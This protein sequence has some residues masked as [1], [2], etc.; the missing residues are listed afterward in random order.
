MKLGHSLVA[1]VIA[2]VSEEEA[3][4]GFSVEECLI[5]GRRELKVSI[6]LAGVAE[7]QLKD[8][9]FRVVSDGGKHLR[10]EWLPVHL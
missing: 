2:D 6:A 7:S 3:A 8:L 5:F 10:F 4:A 1:E 9:L